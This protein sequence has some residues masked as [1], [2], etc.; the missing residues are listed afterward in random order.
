[1]VSAWEPWNRLHGDSLILHHQLPHLAAQHDIRIV[2]V[3]GP[4]PA[5]ALERELKSTYSPPVGVTLRAIQGSSRRLVTGAVN[6]LRS[7]RSGEPAHVHWV[8]R[9]E[10]H[11]AMREEL[12]GFQPEL[13]HLFGWGTAQLHREALGV[14]TVHVATDSWELGVTNRM[15]SRVHRLSDAGQ[16]RRVRAHEHR[17][18]P[19]VGAV[20]VVAERDAEH[21]RERIPG[22]RV[23]VVPNGVDAGAEPAPAA[24]SDD[25]PPV[26]AFH[27]TFSTRANAD[28]ARVLVEQV[29]PLLK[30]TRPD[31]RVMLIGRDAGPEIRA[32]AGPGVEVTGDVVDVRAEL[33][34]AAVYV[35]PLV[36]GS[37]IKNKVLEAMAAGLPVVGTP[38]ALEGIGPS[39]GTIVAAT[40]AQIAD[41]IAA[42]L[43]TPGATREAGKAARQRA[44]VEFS[45]E[46]NASQISAL[47]S[48]IV[49]GARAG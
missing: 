30:A 10:L 49:S 46:S 3:E 45:W 21:L 34:R 5:T 25:P 17:H 27:G 28:A 47:W 40:P 6:R 48:T 20:V 36:S 43:S 23:V 11:R 38:L 2:A 31:V 37:G 7:I 19:A 18:Y 22:C 16:I 12:A 14:P 44:L 15:V 29:L 4:P 9:P 41:A 8:E 32:L 1:M 39:A 24:W 26:V 35:A 33:E 42:L 13:V